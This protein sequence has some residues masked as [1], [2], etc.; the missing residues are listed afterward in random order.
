[1]YTFNIDKI[2]KEALKEDITNQDITTNYLVPDDHISEATILFRESAVVCGLDFAKRVFDLIDPTLKFT[3]LFKDGDTI[4][5]NAKIVK[6][7]Q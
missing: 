3:P 2:I 4:K 7:R 6:L 5:A 1:M